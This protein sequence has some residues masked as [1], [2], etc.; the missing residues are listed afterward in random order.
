[1]EFVNDM[2][3]KFP[4]AEFLTSKDSKQATPPVFLPSVGQRWIVAVKIEEK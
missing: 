3:K 4:A 1:M 2:G